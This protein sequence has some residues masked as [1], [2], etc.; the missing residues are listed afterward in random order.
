MVWKP[1][2]A[3]YLPLP[4]KVLL[5]VQSQIHFAEHKRL[6]LLS[7]TPLTAPEPSVPQPFGYTFL[8]ESVKATEQP[9]P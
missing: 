7:S 4:F 1:P 8:L 9:V 3:L 6:S 2:L 5:P